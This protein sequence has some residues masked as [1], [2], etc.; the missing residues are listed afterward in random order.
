MAQNWQYLPDGGL[1]Q[2]G[3]VTYGGGGSTS[4]LG[5]RNIQDARRVMA[6]G[7][8]PSAEYPDGYLG[9]IID[10]RQDRLFQ[11]LQSRLTDKNYQRGVHKGERVN[12]QDYFWSDTVNPQAALEAQARGLKWTQTGSNIQERLAHM[13]KNAALSPEEM[14]AAY[15]R[16]GVD[17]QM[18]DLTPMNEARKQYLRNLLPKAR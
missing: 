16:F 13:G 17:P 11:K 3:G 14:T 5:F 6:G 4:L 7:R 18:R 9:T 15:Q 8:T 10:R 12:P 1:P 2:P